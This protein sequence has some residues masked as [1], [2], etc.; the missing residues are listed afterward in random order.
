MVGNITFLMIISSSCC[1]CRRRRRPRRASSR[2]ATQSN[3]TGITERTEARTHG[4]VHRDREPQRCNVV[5][6]RAVDAVVG[7][8][9]RY[10]LSRS[11][12]RQFHGVVAIADYHSQVPCTGKKTNKKETQ[13]FTNLRRSR[14]F[15]GPTSC[16]SVI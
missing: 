16:Q 11:G 13:K 12:R 5:V 10:L 15:S 2:I 14:V 6:E 3:I 9:H 7:D 4:G 8:C 1:C